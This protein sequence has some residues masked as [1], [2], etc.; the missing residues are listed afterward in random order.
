MR[1]EQLAGNWRKNDYKWAR[2]AVGRGPDR[3]KKI[4][5]GIKFLSLSFHEKVWP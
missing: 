1:R 5:Q 2:K 3:G 4:L